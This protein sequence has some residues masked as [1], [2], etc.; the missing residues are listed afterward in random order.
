MVAA[1][2]NEFTELV[3]GASSTALYIPQFIDGL[4]NRTVQNALVVAWRK[5]TTATLDKMVELASEKIRFLGIW[6]M[7]M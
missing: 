7:G 3:A 1:Y 2:I 5:G 6:M 4:S